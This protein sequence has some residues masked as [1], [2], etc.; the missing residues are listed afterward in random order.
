MK[1]DLVAIGDVTTDCFIKLENAEELRNHGVV[2]LCMPFGAKLPYESAT[3][4]WATGNSSNAALCVAKLGLSAALVASVGDDDN[5]K[6]IL[7]SL[8]SRGVATEYVTV[9][10]N[11]KTN[12][13]YILQ[14]GAE[15]TI[16]LKHQPFPK[17]IPSFSE[18]PQWL[19]FSSAGDEAFQ[20]SVGRFCMDNHIKLA[21]Q[22]NNEQV[23]AGLALKD[24]YAASDICICN[25]EEA[26]KIL[27]TTE[28]D[29]KKL[30]EDIRSVGPKIVV[31][32][33]GPNGSNI[34]DET[35]AWHIPMYPDPAPP[36]S[37][38]GAGDVTAATTVAYLIKGLAP[39]DA[40]ARGLINAAAGVQAV[41]AQLGTLTEAEVEG[42][43]EKR[44]AD[45]KPT[46]L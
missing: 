36:V 45:F 42:W 8:Q 43:Y 30:M 31:I 15:R 41:H 4:V 3:E 13:Y 21:F 39:K 6:K 35:G 17:V 2:E 34:M 19:Y 5:G 37:R 7:G 23:D 24:V 38:T 40:L 20:N 26:Q 12:Y 29:V 28:E 33:D 27:Q 14:H 22:P 9:H 16:L 10:K 46:A 32:T 18:M 25:K 44:P 11:I 1:Y